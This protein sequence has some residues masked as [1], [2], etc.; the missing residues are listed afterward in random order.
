MKLVSQERPEPAEKR[1]SQRRALFTFCWYKRV[2]DAALDNEEAVANLQDVSDGGLGMLTPQAPPIG[3]RLLVEIVSNVG[4][5]SLLGRVSNCAPLNGRAYR[6]GLR[7]E[8]VP[9]NDLATWRKM[10]S[11]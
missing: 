2:D 9:P 7:V 6:V 11:R 3:A 5:V 10:V 8:T 4:R 1:K